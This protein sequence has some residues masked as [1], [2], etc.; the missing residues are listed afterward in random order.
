[1][2]NDGTIQYLL[3]YNFYNIKKDIM[4]AILKKVSRKWVSQINRK[5]GIKRQKMGVKEG[6]KWELKKG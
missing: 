2:N 5:Q 1:M 4:I 6:A 3:N